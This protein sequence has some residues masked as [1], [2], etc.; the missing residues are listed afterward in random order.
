VHALTENLL[1]WIRK[2]NALRA[3]DRVAVAVSGGADSVALLLLLVEMRPELGIVL[4]IAHVN[5]K[6]RGQESEEDADFVAR[7]AE[8]Y[9]LELHIQNAPIDRLS[10][11][12]QPDSCIIPGLEA[13]ARDLRYAFFRELA[14]SGK[15]SKVVTAHTLD[16][17]AETVLLR[18][19][20]GT[21]IRGLAGIHPRIAFEENGRSYGEV[22][23]PLLSVRR[24]ALQEFLREQGQDWREDSSN[25]NMIFDRNRVRQK[26]LPL[27]AKEFGDAAIEHMRDLA[28][29]ARAEE[30]H[31]Q[32]MHPERR[33]P[34]EDGPQEKSA[35]K[36][37]KLAVDP[38][39]ALPLAAQRRLLV[40][41]L[42]GSAPEVSISFR[43]I[44]EALDLSRAPSGGLLQLADGCNLRRVDR[45]LL[46]ERGTPQ[47]AGSYAY[48]L[49]IPGVVSIPELQAT[50]EALEVDPTS[51]P[52][53]LRGQLLAI[54]RVPRELLIRNWQSGERYWPANTAAPKKIKELLT[55]SHVK[56]FAKKLWPVAELNG[57]GILWMRGFDAP[58]AWQ[59]PHAARRA[60]WI[61]EVS[62]VEAQAMV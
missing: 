58:A 21:G 1:R 41:W 60:I 50:I 36:N 12:N 53:K 56:G 3:G 9:A 24:Q 25:A 4:S 34:E 32:T 27:I 8:K 39:L 33:L 59:A 62:A 54:E 5:H 44:E 40:R 42:E 38:L 45:W 18:I 7:L 17:Q 43:R 31:W 14:K 26:L 52:E 35:K 15:I 49:K 20:R 51:I 37:A 28:E 11:T 47:P 57:S 48:I 10:K 61:R 55:D 22:I 30:D 46:L 19:F 6:L 23:R 2:S 29:I 13:A 16:D